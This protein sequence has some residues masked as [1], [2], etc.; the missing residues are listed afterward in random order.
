MFR[1]ELRTYESHVSSPNINMERPEKNNMQKRVLDANVQ[2][3]KYI[4]VVMII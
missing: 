1:V 2:Q 3:K 4:K